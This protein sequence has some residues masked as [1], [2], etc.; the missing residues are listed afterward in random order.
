[1]GVGRRAAVVWTMLP[2]KRATLGFRNGPNGSQPPNGHP[3][4]GH[5]QLGHPH[6]LRA[7]IPTSNWTGLHGVRWSHRSRLNPLTPELRL[8]A[9]PPRAQPSMLLVSAKL[10]FSHSVHPSLA[11]VVTN[12]NFAT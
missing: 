11:E 6:P 3:Q 4:L 5:P 1:M 12:V 9:C 8:T 7:T 10:A 2:L